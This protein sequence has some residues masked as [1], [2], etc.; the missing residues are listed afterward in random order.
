MKADY[1][2]QEFKNQEF[3]FFQ[4]WAHKGHTKITIQFKIKCTSIN[5]QLKKK[6]RLSCKC[7]FL[8]TY[9]KNA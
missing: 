8:C 9:F 3:L 5:Y 7:Y 2:N 6:Y 4:F 1:K